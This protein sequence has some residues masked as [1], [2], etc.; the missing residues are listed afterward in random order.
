MK[1]FQ[2]IGNSLIFSILLIVSVSSCEKIIPIDLPDQDRKIV[3]N[4]LLAPDSLVNVNLSLSLSVLEPDS[5]LYLSDAEVDL[6]RD[7]ELLGRMVYDSVGFYSL[8]GVRAAVGEEYRITATK[9]GMASAEATTTIQSPV[10]ILTL[11]TTHEILDYGQQ[12]V[13]F[14]ITFDDPV[15][16]HYYGVSAEMTYDFGGF[17]DL[18]FPSERITTSVYL[19]DLD[20]FLEEEG[21]NYRGSIY[22]SDRLFEGASKSIEVGV[23][24]YA[25]TFS[26]TVWITIRLEKIEEAYY[27]YAISSQAYYEAHSNP[28][29]E[30]VKVFTNVN[31]GFGI[32]SSRSFS[33]RKFIFWG[34]GYPR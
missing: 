27:L 32:L 24:D 3:I 29:S 33:E 31:G 1:L 7:N 11:D 5:F 21:V 10:S 26:D 25:L 17:D 30:P 13:N 12:L 15:G 2:N 16:K 34:T 9:G 23:S 6:Y 14:K 22:F 28:F 19:S 20:A 4:G 8:P 18:G